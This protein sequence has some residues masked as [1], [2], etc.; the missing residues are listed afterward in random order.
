MS[1]Y[2]LAPVAQGCSAPKNLPVGIRP[3]ARVTS[4]GSTFISLEW[5]APQLP[6]NCASEVFGFPSLTYGVFIH[7]GT[8]IGENIQVDYFIMLYS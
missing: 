3:R 2:F 6:I 4:V 5:D 7:I 1:V 8:P